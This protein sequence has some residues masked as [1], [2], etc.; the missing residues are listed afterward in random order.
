MRQ[1]SATLDFSDQRQLLRFMLS[2]V[3]RTNAPLAR[4]AALARLLVL[5]RAYGDISKDVC[6]AAQILGRRCG[7][8]PDHLTDLASSYENWDGSGFPGKAAGEAIPLP[9][10]VVQVASLAVAG[11]RHGGVRG[12]AD[13]VRERSGRGLDPSVSVAFLADP[14]MVLAPIQVVGSLWD[15]VVAAAPEVAPMAPDEVDDALR[16]IAD[17]TD[18]KSPYLI[19][20]SSGVAELA[21]HAAVVAGLEPEYMCLLRRA[22]Y[23]HDIGR[24][25]ISASIWGRPGPLRPDEWELVRLHPYYT[26]RVLDRTPFLREL[27]AVASQHHERLDGSGYSRGIERMPKPARILAAADVYHAMRERRPHR[28]AL[29]PQAAATQLH[30]EVGAR[31]LDGNAVDAVLEAVANP[32]PTDL[33]TIPGLTA[34]EVGVLIEVGRGRDNK[35]IGRTLGLAAKQVDG[36]LASIYPTIGVGTR[37]G[38]TLYALERRIVPTIV[39][40]SPHSGARSRYA[41]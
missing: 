7:Y 3:A 32:V 24:I 39:R 23:V 34:A 14:D 28:P 8:D 35:E 16:A 6:E 12:G 31:H 9:V 21:A 29:T 26:D 13:L 25:G 2:H 5:G 27:S 37:A 19:G 38:A 17:F 30:A 15:A 22:G 20:H 10:R 40:A 11:H 41:D 1:H 18:L 33:P 4:P 36:M